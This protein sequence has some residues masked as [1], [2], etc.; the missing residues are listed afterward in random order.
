MR[1]RFTYEMHLQKLCHCLCSFVYLH[2]VSQNVGFNENQ[3]SDCRNPFPNI[4]D[5]RAHCLEYFGVE[6]V[7]H[8]WP[9]QETETEQVN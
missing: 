6:T 3:L 8:C 4:S 5:L 1:S 9:Y 7:V 2:Q